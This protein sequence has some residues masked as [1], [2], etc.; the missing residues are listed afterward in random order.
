MT[1]R[2]GLSGYLSADGAV[3]SSH[4]VLMG[5]PFD[6]TASFRPG[7]RFAPGAIRMWSAVLESYC[8]VFDA[9]LEELSLADAGDIVAPA[10]AWTAVSECVRKTVGAAVAAGQSPLLM[11]GEHL[12]T[13]PAVEGCLATCPDLVVIQMDAHMDLRNDYEGRKHSHATVMRRVFDLVGPGG[14]C[15]Y[16][17]RS[18]TREEWFFSRKHGML[19]ANAG[20]LAGIVGQR[21]VY[22][23]VDLDVL[24]PSVMPETGTPE[25]GGLSYPQLRDAL[26]PL[27]G[28]RIVGADVV[29]Y[30]PLAGMGGPSGA[31]AAKVVRDLVFLI[32]E[33]SHPRPRI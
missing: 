12:V 6:Q 26:M 28:A 13:L 25:P 20:D 2:T 15:Q 3:D 9:D 1:L 24:D 5:V 18:G 27:R 31:V 22:L 19:L 33:S 7:A 8:P 30:C 21:P 29:E 11:G 14:L 23:S 17:I 4:I 10:S 32:A 16:G